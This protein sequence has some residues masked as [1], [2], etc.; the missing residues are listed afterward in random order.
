M[1][2]H[3]LLLELAYELL[4]FWGLGRLQP[5]LGLDVDLLEGF[6]EFVGGEVV[7][8]RVGVEEVSLE[9][10]KLGC[11]AFCVA[12]IR[13]VVVEEFNCAL[14]QILGLTDLEENFLKLPLKMFRLSTDDLFLEQMSPGLVFWLHLAIEAVLLTSHFILLVLFYLL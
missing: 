2:L 1:S 11:E 3:V 14:F 12:E 9:E 7:E 6:W 8:Q 10:V 5:A 13:G 4:V